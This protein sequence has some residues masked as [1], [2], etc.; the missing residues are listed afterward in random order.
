[1]LVGA[2]ATHGDFNPANLLETSEY[3]AFLDFED[4]RHMHVWP[5]FDTAK[6][7]ERLILTRESRFGPSW[8]MLAAGR[9]LRGYSE[10][11]SPPFKP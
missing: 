8:A 2:V 4:M 10:P 6:L 9:L 3:V 7:I 1:M 5:S 11:P